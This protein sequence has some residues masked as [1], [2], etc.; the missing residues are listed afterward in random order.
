[1]RKA[2]L[3]T[4]QQ[5]RERDRA[6]PITAL[7]SQRLQQSPDVTGKHQ[8]PKELCQ[9]EKELFSIP[10]C[11]PQQSF[12]TA[13]QEGSSIFPISDLLRAVQSR[14][15]HGCEN[16]TIPSAISAWDRCSFTT[17]LLP[18]QLPSLAPGCTP[19]HPG[20]RGHCS[21]ACSLYSVP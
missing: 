14:C 16:K 4:Q 18:P 21:K 7:G 8:C 11:L 6:E 20:C 1:M 15:N 10:E 9:H 19:P 13:R 12:Y 17:A 2:G 5:G 3:V